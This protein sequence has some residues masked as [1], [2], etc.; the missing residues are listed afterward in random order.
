[1]SLKKCKSTTEIHKIYNFSLP[2]LGVS[3]IYHRLV[4]LMKKMFTCMESTYVGETVEMSDDT[5]GNVFLQSDVVLI[6]DN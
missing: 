1:L 6:L 5:S 2:L 3:A 4:A